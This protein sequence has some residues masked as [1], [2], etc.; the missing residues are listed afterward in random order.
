MARKRQRTRAERDYVA[1]VQNL[2]RGT[3]ARPVDRRRPR[4]TERRAA[5][6]DAQRGW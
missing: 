2:R 5:I 1:H 3:A 6:R 4:G